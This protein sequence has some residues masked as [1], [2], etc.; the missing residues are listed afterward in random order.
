MGSITLFCGIGKH[1]FC[2]QH[3]S[4][5]HQRSRVYMSSCL[6]TSISGVGS[7]SKKKSKIQYRALLRKIDRTVVKF[8][9]YDVDKLRGDAVS[10]NISRTNKAFPAVAGSWRAQGDQWKGA[11]PCVVQIRVWHR[12]H[13]MREHGH[14]RKRQPCAD[15]TWICLFGGQGHRST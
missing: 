11:R 7:G 13:G 8:R 5:V 12:I 3:I 2:W 9:P 6:D 4:T 1:K 14:S 10:L 15:T